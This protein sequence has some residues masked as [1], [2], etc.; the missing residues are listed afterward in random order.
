MKKNNKIKILIFVII[1]IIIATA[2][3]IFIP[4]HNSKVFD[5]YGKEELIQYLNNIEDEQIKKEE[6]DNAIEKGWITENDLK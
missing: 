3:A 1:L 5:D 2:L 6:I 4:F